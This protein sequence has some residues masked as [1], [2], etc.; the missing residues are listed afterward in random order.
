MFSIYRYVVKQKS[1]K[2]P[3]NKAFYAN[4]SVNES[5]LL[6]CFEYM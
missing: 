5:V 1:L 4:E 6:I 2:T 3:R